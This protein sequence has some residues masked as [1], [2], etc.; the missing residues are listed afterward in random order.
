[1]YIIIVPGELG[2]CSLNILDT[3]FSGRVNFVGSYLLCLSINKTSGLN[4][5]RALAC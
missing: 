4:V 3:K 1:M 2:K 5:F